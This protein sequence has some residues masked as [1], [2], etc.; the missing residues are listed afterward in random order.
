MAFFGDD[1]IL[2]SGLRLLPIG[3]S[4]I[5][6]IR[7]WRNSQMS[8]LRQ[9]EELSSRD[10]VKYFETVVWP[11][12]QDLRPSQ[13]IYL[14]EFKGQVVGYGGV[15]HISWDHLRGEVSFLLRPEIEKNLEL[16]RE[17]FSAFLRVIT[18]LAFLRLKINK[19]FTETF[20][21]RGDHIEILEQNLFVREGRLRGHVWIDGV[22]MD[23]ILHGILREDKVKGGVL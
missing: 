22:S 15:V 11:H 9:S 5:E 17:I 21:D 18:D 20:E 3:R 19:L 8:V 23:S 16:K 1:A 10:Q 7:V 6:D 4:D 13:V 2:N 12:T 14:L